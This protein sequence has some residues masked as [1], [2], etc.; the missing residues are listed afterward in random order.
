MSDAAPAL[1]AEGEL[2]EAPEK[3]CTDA[4]AIWNEFCGPAGWPA[5]RFLTT[6]RRAALRRA[7]PDY[8]GLA[9]WK[10]HLAAASH[11]DFLTG[12]TDRDEK[13]RNW[14]PDLDWFLKPAN[15]IKILE[16]KFPANGAVQQAGAR[17]PHAED[18]AKLRRYRPGGFWPA[19][20]GPRPEEQACRLPL[21]VLA[22]WREQY[23]V[24]PAVSAKR[25]E[26]IEERLEGSIRAYDRV[27]NHARADQ[28]RGELA[29]LRGE[30][31]VV[32]PPRPEAPQN[33]PRPSGPPEGA[34]DE[35][36]AVPIGQDCDDE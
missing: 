2:A 1:F 25:V 29:K 22:P 6:S 18:R 36:D 9:G 20:W 26:T 5:A 21:E 11:N 17:D 23:N 35:Y 4:L 31:A 33:Q 30:S 7:I 32:M 15:V 3:L 8:G 19:S 12:K 27:G 14:K 28:L 13:H 10:S 16:G 24:A 34:C